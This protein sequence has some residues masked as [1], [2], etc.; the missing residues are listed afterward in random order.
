M[1]PIFHTRKFSFGMDLKRQLQSE[2]SV[3]D[4][5][6][7]GSCAIVYNCVVVYIRCIECNIGPLCSSIWVFKMAF[8][9]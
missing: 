3:E 8:V 5:D 6:W 2:K 9:A 1:F 7:F 4:G